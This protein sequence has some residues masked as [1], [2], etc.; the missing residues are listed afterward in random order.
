MHV[1]HATG[2]AF[3]RLE[4]ATCTG[5]SHACDWSSMQS[6]RKSDV[7]RCKSCMRLG[8]HSVGV[9]TFVSIVQHVVKVRFGL[10][11]L[12][13]PGKV[14]VEDKN[15]K[16]AKVSLL[17][18]PDA[19]IVLLGRRC[20]R[21]C[22][23]CLRRVDTT[24]NRSRTWTC[25]RSAILHRRPLCHAMAY[26]SRSITTAASQ[27]LSYSRRS[28]SRTTLSAIASM[29]SMTTRTRTSPSLTTR[30]VLKYGT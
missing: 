29:S 13:H 1:M 25:W 8:V 24:P 15:R 7:H 9:V 21:A 11:G 28:C 6:D 10:G 12:C 22:P 14:P 3:S 23:Q 27:L 17:L 16:C 26:R 5:V 20:T 30:S 19:Q 4:R 2:R 18:R